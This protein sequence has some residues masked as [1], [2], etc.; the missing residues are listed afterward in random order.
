MRKVCDYCNN[1]TS[2]QCQSNLHDADAFGLAVAVSFSFVNQEPIVGGERL[3]CAGVLKNYRSLVIAA[4]TVISR[5]VFKT[6]RGHV[7]SVV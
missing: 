6:D 5:F 7:L 1:Q 4:V 2:R 3:I